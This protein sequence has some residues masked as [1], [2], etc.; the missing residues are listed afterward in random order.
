MVQTLYFVEIVL[1]KKKTFLMIILL[2]ENF[3]IPLVNLYLFV[4]KCPR[5]GR[6]PSKWSLKGP[7]SH[8]HHDIGSLRNLPKTKPV[9]I[10]KILINFNETLYITFFEPEKHEKQG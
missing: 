6:F 7:F 10:V 3:Q 8:K 4:L 5:F 1:L 9:L 2:H